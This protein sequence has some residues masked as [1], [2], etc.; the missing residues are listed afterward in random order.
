MADAR[1]FP[2]AGPFPL[3]RLAEIAEAQLSDGAFADRLFVDVAALDE[4]GPEH[5]SFLENRRYLPALA[6]TRAGACLIHPSLAERAPPGTA[7]LLA[8]EPYRGY[9]RIAAAFHPDLPPAGGIHARAVVDPTALLE[10]GVVVEAGAVIGAR[11]RLGARVWI[12]PNAVI[13]DAVEIGA[14]SRVGAGASVSHALVGKRV[15]IYPGARI[16]QDGFGFAMSPAGHLK[17]PQLGRVLIGDDVEVGANSTVDRGSA[18]D[19]VIGDGTLIDNLVQIGHNVRVGRG[20]VIVAQV[21]IA[22]SARLDDFVVVGGQV[23]IAGHLRIGA[24]ARIAAQSGVHRDV[25]AGSEL[26]GTPAVPMSEFRRLCALWRIQVQERMKGK[27]ARDED[28][29]S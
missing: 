8:K 12:G 29:T 24:G 16:G 7:L 18:S 3:A 10:P 26:G 11:A 19:T 6:A 5:V 1:F 21:G 20:C 22:G 17:V 27:R 14:D 28:G 23:G 2:L 25:P 13:G 15:R 9:A 4:A